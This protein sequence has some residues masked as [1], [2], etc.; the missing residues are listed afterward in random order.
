[1]SGGR[2]GELDSSEGSTR[3]ALRLIESTSAVVAPLTLLTALLFYIG[4]IRTRTFYGYFGLSPSLVGFSPQDYVLR[5][6]EISFGAVLLLVLAGVILLGLDRVL[7]QVLKR[8][9]GR[10]NQIRRSLAVVG[11]ILVVGALGHASA[12][13]ALAAVPAATGAVLLALGAIMFLRFGA[14]A[15]E[16]S[17]TSRPAIGL[18]VA[19][20]VVAGF[21]ASTSFAQ[22]LGEQ[23]AKAVD[24]DARGMAIV[25]IYSREELDLPG[26]HVTATRTQDHE[27]QWRYRYTGARLLTYAN[28]RWFLIPEPAAG[29]YR[30][31]VTM[32]PDT[33]AIRVEMAAPR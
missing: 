8:A 31:T 17:A 7:V 32:I 12:S 9:H 6:A 16:Q 2:R 1:V 28:S 26:T 20:L 15:G 27:S 33:D 11:A 5:S 10:E 21:W 4:W 23:A 30:S 19:A 3:S 29:S 14:I 22:S 25:T 18:V 24:R 13:A